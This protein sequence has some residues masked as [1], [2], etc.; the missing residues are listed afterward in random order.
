MTIE[1]TKLLQNTRTSNVKEIMIFVSWNCRGLG[2]SNKVEAIKNMIRF[3]K[4]ILMIQETKMADEGVMAL[5][6]IH[7]LNYQ[8]KSISSKGASGGITTFYNSEKYAMSLVKET[9]HWL[10]I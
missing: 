5:S 3:E 7:W 8:G 4:P 9:N 2:S 6:W 10:L 1:E